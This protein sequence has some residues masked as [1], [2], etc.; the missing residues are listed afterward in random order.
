MKKPDGSLTSSIDE[1]LQSWT[2]H[3]DRLF[4]PPSVGP[5][6][7]QMNH[8]ENCTHTDKILNIPITTEEI[9][10]ALTQLDESKTPGSDK[11]CP[12]ILKDEKIM[13]YLQILFQKCFNSGTVPKAWLHST[14]TPIFK[15]SGS[16]HDHNNYRGITVQSCVAKA[17]CKILNN[18]I[19]KYL[20]ANNILHD[21]Q[22]GFRK[23]RSCQDH[24]S[25]LYFLIEN[26][27]LANL[28]TYACFVDFK[29]AFDSV[30]RELLWRKLIKIGIRGELLKSLKALYTNL[31]SS[32]KVNDRLSPAFKVGRGVKQGCTLSPILFNIFI[33]DLIEYLN[34]AVEGIEIE[35][36]KINTLLFADDVV[37]IADCPIKLQHLL[38]AL[39]KWCKDN[40]MMINHDKTNFIHFRHP[41]KKLCQ[42]TF[43]CN[44]TPI[45]YTDSYKYLGVEFTEYLSWAKSVENTAISAN[46]AASYLIA[47]TR[48]SS[49]FLFTIYNHLYTTLVLPVIE[50]SSFIWGLRPFD[51]ISKIQNNLM[52]SFLGVGRNAPIVTLIGDMG[53]APISIT[54]KLSCIRFWQR[55]SNMSH[56]RLNYKI[57]TESC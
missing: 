38:D 1:T 31:Y 9:H 6:L 32:V 48:S 45:Q 3:F 15:G 30:P 5:D 23:K 8:S 12:S 50:Y 26:R 10:S 37:L 11:I 18:R 46:K 52:R 49:V 33:N 55:L 19:D 16:R 22:N 47:K 17:F 41:K 36:T 54:T 20:L 7:D 34:E 14:I 24:I 51:Q 27:K 13:Q 42:S 28:D 56:D 40:Q 4:N 57:F 39:G 29:K 25:S 35:N 53:W 21:E 43:S 44:E 2:D